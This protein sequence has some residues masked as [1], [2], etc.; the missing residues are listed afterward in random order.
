MAEN[1]WRRNIEVRGKICESLQESQVLEQRDS[2]THHDI[3]E[4]DD[5]IGLELLT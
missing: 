2:H 4:S 3:T 1:K 5:F